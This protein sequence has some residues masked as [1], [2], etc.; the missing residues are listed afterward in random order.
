MTHLVENDIAHDGSWQISILV[1]D[2]NIQRSLYVTGSLHI[3]GLML[4]LVD[5]VDMS[6]DWSDHALWWPEK[7]RWLT[8]TRSTLDQI[9]VTANCNLEF[10]PQHKLAMFVFII[11]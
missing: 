11:I 5:E 4:R 6:K 1:T 10:T 9:G 3:G 7:R 2:L 8:H